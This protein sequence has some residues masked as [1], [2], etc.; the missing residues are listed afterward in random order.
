VNENEKKSGERRRAQTRQAPLRYSAADAYAILDIELRNDRRLLRLLSTQRRIHTMRQLSRR[1]DAFGLEIWS[2]FKGG[3][4]SEIVERDDGYIDAGM[5]VA[6]Y[7]ADFR[8]WPTRQKRAMQFVTGDKALDVGC[9]AGRVSLYLQSKGFRVTAID[10]SPLAIRTCTKRGVRDA[11]VFA[12]EDIHRLA[13][14]QF[15]TLVL[16]GNNFGLFG[17]Q[18]KAKRLLKQLHRITTAGA[19]IVAETV[20]PYRTSNPFHRQYQQRNRKR[21]R[22]PGQIRMRIRFQTAATPWFDY[23]LV[24]PVEMKNIVNGTGWRVRR[25]LEGNRPSYVAVIDRV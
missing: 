13:E 21:G 20:N 14:N 4:S 15:D 5:S 24:S 7:F 2:C 18:V 25:L 22:M 16:F 3:P 23:L 11:R 17:N 8:R 10:V 12:F 9:G 6:R 1:N 19:V